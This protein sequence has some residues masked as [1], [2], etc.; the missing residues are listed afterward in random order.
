MVGKTKK[1]TSN[2]KKKTLN[3]VWN[4]KCTIELPRDEELLEIS[5]WDHDVFSRNDFIGCLSLSRKQLIDH[6]NDPQFDGWFKL[7]KVSQGSIQLKIRVFVNEMPA[8]EPNMTSSASQPSA[9][10]S[11]DL[12]ASP[13]SSHR[14]LSS[15]FYNADATSSDENSPGANHLSNYQQVN[16]L[17]ASQHRGSPSAKCRLQ[18]QIN[19]RLKPLNNG[20]IR[21]LMNDSSSFR[22]EHLRGSMKKVAAL[23]SKAKSSK[24]ELPTISSSLYK[25]ITFEIYLIEG[26]PSVSQHLQCV[27]KLKSVQGGQ[28]KKLLAKSSQ[29]IPS[30]P[31]VMNFKFTVDERCGEKKESLLFISIKSGFF[32][33]L[34]KVD[35]P[36]EAILPAKPEHKQSTLITVDNIQIHVNCSYQEIL[37]GNDM[38][39]KRSRKKSQ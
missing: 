20:S 19:S 32:S 30:D 35:F 22:R 15:K 11:N 27:V 3:P 13:L 29:F 31:M 1:Y 38:S 25:G 28:R 12:L 10:H 14:Q 6:S 18:N 33:H 5:V 39:Y 37:D 24:E 23:L 16:A 4:E 8:A 34:A 26:L 36:L 7:E 21:S 9:L 17:L 2:V